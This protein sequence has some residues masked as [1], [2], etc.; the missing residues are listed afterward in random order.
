MCRACEEKKKKCFDLQAPS[1]WIHLRITCVSLMKSCFSLHLLPNT[2]FSPST[3]ITVSYSAQFFIFFF[4]PRVWVR[5]PRQV[6]NTIPSPNEIITPRQ[7][8]NLRTFPSIIAVCHLNPCLSQISS[9]GWRE[10]KRRVPKHACQHTNFCVELLSE[11]LF[12]YTTIF[13]NV[14]IVTLSLKMNFKSL[15]LSSESKSGKP[16][17]LIPVNNF[18]P[19]TCQM[20]S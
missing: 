19:P 6:I 14:S 13:N 7:I 8:H 11:R 2:S 5:S 15:Q 17:Q 1:C 3:T 16:A 10:E 4:N 20:E 18:I 12:D 9:V